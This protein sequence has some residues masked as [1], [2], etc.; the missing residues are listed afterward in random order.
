MQVKILSS[1][2]AGGQDLLAGAIAQVS[3]QDGQ[4]LIKMGKAEA[5]TAPAVTKKAPKKRG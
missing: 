3:D 1:T 2:V 5:Y 4:T